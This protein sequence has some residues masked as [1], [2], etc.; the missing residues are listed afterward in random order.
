MPATLDHRSNS[1]CFCAVHEA[2]RYKFEIPY[3]SLKMLQFPTVG[4]KSKRCDVDFVCGQERRIYIYFSSVRF[5][6]Q[7]N[8]RLGNQ[9]GDPAQEPC[10]AQIFFS[11]KHNTQ[12]WM[13]PRTENVFLIVPVNSTLVRK[14]G[15]P[16][17]SYYRTGR[18]GGCQVTTSE[19][20]QRREEMSVLFPPH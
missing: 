3:Y 12:S 17:I 16:P 10:R 15:V 2:T 5:E 20:W 8:I 4:Q 14:D 19:S 11:R 9:V 13:I 7:P 18:G 6:W 1:L